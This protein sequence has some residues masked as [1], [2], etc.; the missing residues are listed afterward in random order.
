MAV[1]AGA[2]VAGG[3]GAEVVGGLLA[4]SQLPQ[5]RA[6][7][8]AEPLAAQ[9]DARALLRLLKAFLQARTI[10]PN[11]KPSLEPLATQPNARALLRL[12]RAFL[13]ARTLNPNVPP[14]HEQSRPRRS[15]T[16]SHCCACSKR[17]SRAEPLP[18]SGAHTPNPGPW[19]ARR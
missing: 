4:G 3:A 18:R 1:R 5:L 8:E 6:V 2:Y 10:Y 12:L 11:S 7:L 15:W 16:R 19:D 17:L 13:Q 14:C 9:L